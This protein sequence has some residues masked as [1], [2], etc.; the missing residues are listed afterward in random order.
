M[1]KAAV[2]LFQLLVQ[3]GA[4]PGDDFS[5]D[6]DQQAYRLNERCYELLQSAYPDVNWLDVLGVPYADVSKEIESLHHQLN[7][8]FVDNL[9]ARMSFRLET[10]PDNQAAGYVQVL[11]TGVERA[12]G[13][14]LYPLLAK[15]LA[16]PGQAR[17]EWLLRQEAVEVPE[18]KCLLDLVL[19]AGGSEE[20]YDVRQGELW[21]TEVGYQR[22]SLVWDGGCIQAN[23]FPRP[24]S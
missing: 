22:L 14:A 18:D 1:H 9:V 13:I 16:I 12:T 24:Q 7:C 20:E 3:A 6:I 10:L 8:P 17:L 15:R 21:L 19:A 2:D 5:C 23:D 11:L 4:V